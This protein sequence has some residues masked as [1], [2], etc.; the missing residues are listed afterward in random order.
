[1]DRDEEL[2]LEV[3]KEI[4]SERKIS[5][6][7]RIDVTVKDGVVTLGGYVDHYM[8]QVAAVAATERVSG[9]EG[10]VQEIEVELPPN[11]KREDIEIA[12]SACAA[13]EHNSTIPGDHVK[14][15]V[16]DGWVTL[17]GNLPEEHQK[18]EAENTASRVLGIKAVT[19]NIV[20]KPQVKPFDVTL[21]IERAFQHMAVHHAREI[22]VDIKDGKVVL[23]GVVRA[24]I[25][26]FEAEEAAHEVPGVVEV[27]N[28]LEVTPLLEG[29]E[30]PP[31]V[32]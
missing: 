24:W 29:K 5:N 11:S 23:S 7:N 6:P 16:C 27:E 2:R 14:V 17:E 25:E 22:H 18:E 26:K 15:S 13:L 12:R 9:V 30:Q 21:Q 4:K 8:D 31:A 20:V 32:A 1:M 10:V 19:N 28:R 3:L